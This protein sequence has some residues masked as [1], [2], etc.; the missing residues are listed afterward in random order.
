L[1]RRKPI[2]T[3]VGVLIM[4]AKKVAK[5]IKVDAFSDHIGEII[6]E[7]KRNNEK[8]ISVEIEKDL[9]NDVYEKLLSKNINAQ[10]NGDL[11][12]ISW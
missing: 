4:D 5:K 11:I 9:I 8:S 3:V 2:K 10:I 12:D 7:A 6:K 1:A